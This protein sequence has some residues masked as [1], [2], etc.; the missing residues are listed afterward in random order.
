MS[1]AAPSSPLK[2]KPSD[3]SEDEF[4]DQP[5]RGGTPSDKYACVFYQPWEKKPWLSRVQHPLNQLEVY[6]SSH[7]S[8]VEAASA[9]NRT[10]TKI[11]IPL[12]NPP[13]NTSSNY[14]K[15][16]TDLLKAMVEKYGQDWH[17]VGK[18][19]NRYPDSVKKQYIAATT[20]S[21][22][23]SRKRKGTKSG[24]LEKS[25]QLK[26]VSL[27]DR[28]YIASQYQKLT[29]TDEK[30]F[31][32]SQYSGVTWN[33]EK[34]IWKASLR[35]K[36][37]IHDLGN[38]WDV[39]EAAVAVNKKCEELN[40]RPRNPGVVIT[41]KSHFQ[42]VVWDG[43][44]W[45][46]QLSVHNM[47]KRV[48][49]CKDFKT[50][51][52][53]ARAVNAMCDIYGIRP[54]NPQVDSR[55]D[56]VSPDVI[57]VMKKNALKPTSVFKG[58]MFSF[59]SDGL[60]WDT[61]FWN[62][63][64]QR[65]ETAGRF[66][67]ELEAAHAVNYKCDELG[68]PRQNSGLS[69][70]RVL[71]DFNFKRGKDVKFRSPSSYKHLGIIPGMTQHE[72]MKRIFDECLKGKFS[73]LKWFNTTS[74]IV[75]ERLK[76]QE[77]EINWKNESVNCGRY[78]VKNDHMRIQSSM[79]ASG[80]K[81]KK[82]ST[83]VKQKSNYINV[84][85]HSTHGRWYGRVY[86]FGK[87][88]QGPYYTTQLEAAKSVN[89]MCN[90]LNMDLK[91]PKLGSLTLA[92]SVQE[93]I[94]AKAAAAYQSRKRG[95]DDAGLP[96]K[97][98]LKLACPNGHVLIHSLSIPKTVEYKNGL[99]CDICE[100]TYT[101]GAD[102]GRMG[103]I[104][105]C[106]EE[107]AYDVCRVCHDRQTGG[108][109]PKKKPSVPGP[110]FLKVK[111]EISLSN[112]STPPISREMV[113]LPA[114]AQSQLTED[115]VVEV[116]QATALA[117]KEEPREYTCNLIR[118]S[119]E[120]PL[121]A[122][123]AIGHHQ[124]V[125]RLLQANADPLTQSN[126]GLLPAHIAAKKG[127][128]ECLKLLLARDSD[129]VNRCI[130]LASQ[131]GHIT[132]SQ[133]LRDVF[134]SPRQLAPGDL[135]QRRGA[136]GVV[137]SFAQTGKIEVHFFDGDMMWTTE[138]KVDRVSMEGLK[139]F[140]ERNE[141]IG[142]GEET[143]QIAESI[144]NARKTLQEEMKKMEDAKAA[145][146]RELRNAQCGVESVKDAHYKAFRYV[147]SL[148]TQ[149]MNLQTKVNKERENMNTIQKKLEDAKSALKA[150]ATEK[151]VECAKYQE[152]VDLAQA[153]LAKLMEMNPNAQSQIS[154]H[155][156]MLSNA[157]SFLRRMMS[158]KPEE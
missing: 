59:A 73:L 96:P 90:L 21:P 34:R 146:E 56:L 105:M 86:Y 82:A 22:Q 33:K 103:G 142:V 32:M 144:S 51:L 150:K 94:L 63:V 10:C 77:W 91:H 87:Y 152:K 1:F 15:L 58:V 52:D 43:E 115:P 151:E 143:K 101:D 129:P 75:R 47:P 41:K 112:L 125:Q 5:F 78:A 23:R 109:A 156:M 130:K 13:I 92:D 154:E 40:I 139:S 25:G 37:E 88:F 17:T 27:R 76:N 81:S 68:M 108:Y 53:A 133:Y 30:G 106:P 57:D 80:Q 72:V 84:S 145:Q 50:D 122:E 55:L 118:N 136:L 35:V 39:D 6:E 54:Y 66:K 24:K 16:E 141:R 113:D 79:A 140:I 155:T 100:I 14:T 95:N 121:C 29:F 148:E 138:K 153:E 61:A 114:F 71:A 70:K 93:R 124:C 119:T 9:V 157:K 116:K 98:R 83:P 120:P 64:E 42:G 3:K 44:T 99:C 135:V 2:L 7:G 149:L 131:N 28:R 85:W 38:Y 97:K 89:A 19:M 147:K 49:E 26:K 8:E 128:L 46:A 65:F 127:H 18:A 60:V 62:E 31:P 111:E 74:F 102:V 110:K 132:I 104:W 117:I 137:K 158:V 20:P 11:S 12:L 36:G 45:C 123:A 67:N 69:T 48:Y 134:G 126:L 4:G 107:C